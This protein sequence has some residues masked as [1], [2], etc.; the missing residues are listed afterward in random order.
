MKTT[1]LLS[2]SVITFFFATSSLAQDVFIP[3]PKFDSDYDKII[4]KA[5]SIKAAL[6]DVEYISFARTCD[7]NRKQFKNIDRIQI[8]DMVIVPA[9]K[10]FSV[11]IRAQKGDCLWTITKK[12]REMFSK[13]I[14]PVKEPMIIVMDNNFFPR[15]TDKPFNLPFAVSL[16]TFA[17]ACLSLFLSLRSQ[18]QIR[19]LKKQLREAEEEKRRLAGL[20]NEEEEN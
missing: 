3:H 15:K 11:M 1:L 20:T 5:D 19:L 9:G 13:S 14:L 7:A 16:I 2:I 17:I 18:R 4:R 10:D 8:G 6:I 12:A